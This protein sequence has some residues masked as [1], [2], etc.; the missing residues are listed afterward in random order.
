[1]VTRSHHEDSDNVQGDSASGATC[2][3]DPEQ[4]TQLLKDH[5]QLKMELD[6]IKNSTPWS[7]RKETV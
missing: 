1:M 3:V 2:P 5:I 7:S 4:Y 6:V